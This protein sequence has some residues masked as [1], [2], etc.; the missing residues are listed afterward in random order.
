MNK[1][2]TETS[3][4]SLHTQ[5]L[6]D[7][8]HFQ[9]KGQDRV[10]GNTSLCLAAVGQMRRDCDFA[11]ATNCHAHD[12]NVPAF[13]DFAGAELE[14]KWFAFFVCCNKAESVSMLSDHKRL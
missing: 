3:N 9:I 2:N 11:L 13:D 14:C 7:V 6:F 4:D 5:C 12:A 1:K 8:K 10:C